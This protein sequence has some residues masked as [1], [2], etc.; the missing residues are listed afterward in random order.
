MLFLCFSPLPLFL[1][2][3]EIDTRNYIYNY[4]LFWHLVFIVGITLNN[5]ALTLRYVNKLAYP[6]PP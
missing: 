2:S 4:S 6:T 5:I 1:L 3:I